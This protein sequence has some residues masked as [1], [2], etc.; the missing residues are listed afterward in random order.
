MVEEIVSEQ[1]NYLFGAT[2]VSGY[3]SRPS[4]SGTWPSIVV[5]HARSGLDEHIKD[6]TRRF[7][8]EGYV[9][10]APDLYHGRV[11]ANTEEAIHLQR[12]LNYAQAAREVIAAIPYL[13]NQ[14]FVTG[15]VAVLGYCM[16]GTISLLAACEGAEWD[17]AVT[18]YGSNPDP[19]EKVQGIRCPMLGIYGDADPVVPPLEVTRIREAMERHGKRFDIHSYPEAKHAFFDDSGRNYHPEATRQAWSVTLAFLERHLS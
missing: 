10:L 17:A 5:I 19:I 9:A 3:T 14:S 11:A 7:A 15:K 4:G 6:V 16:G 1:V 18:Y 2:T 13:R 12:A 8:K